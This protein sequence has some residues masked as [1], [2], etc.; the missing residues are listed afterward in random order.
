MNT[1][2][3]LVSLLTTLMICVMVNFTSAAT[4]SNKENT[5]QQQQQIPTIYFGV[6]SMGSTQWTSEGGNSISVDVSTSHLQLTSIPTYVTRIITRNSQFNTFDTLPG[7][8]VLANISGVAVPRTSSASGFKMRLRSNDSNKNLTVVTAKANDFRVV[9]MAA[10]S[11]HPG[12]ENFSPNSVG[13]HAELV[14]QILYEEPVIMKGF[15]LP[16]EIAKAQIV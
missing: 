12:I 6:T 11:K 13:A 10:T 16:G 1:V 2:N 5:K 15:F 3:L 7:L 9:W 4:D 14:R 8:D